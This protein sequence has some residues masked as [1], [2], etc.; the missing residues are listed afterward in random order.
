MFRYLVVFEK[1][2]NG[3]SAFVPDLPGCAATGPDKPT[4][5]KHIY[6]AIQ[7]HIEGLQAE[8]QA[9]PS[10]NAESEV[11]VFSG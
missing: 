10:G 11:L 1:T 3:F 8:K 4:T 7:F 2:A 6:E 9:I 5:E